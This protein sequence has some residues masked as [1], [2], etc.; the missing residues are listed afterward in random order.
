MSSSSGDFYTFP[1]RDDGVVEIVVSEIMA[2]AF[3]G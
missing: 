1:R 2:I 3:V